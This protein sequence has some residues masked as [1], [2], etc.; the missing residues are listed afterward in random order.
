MPLKYLMYFLSGINTKEFWTIPQEKYFPPLKIL[1]LSIKFF[2]NPFVDIALT[3]LIVH[4]IH[5]RQ[6]HTLFYFK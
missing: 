1:Y 3:F 6:V 4:L 2:V 5:F